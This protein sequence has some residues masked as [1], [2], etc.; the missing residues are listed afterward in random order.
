[1]DLVEGPSSLELYHGTAASRVESIRA[2]GLVPPEPPRYPGC[3]AMLTSSWD[4]AV[5]NS[6][7]QPLGDR[8]VI[9]YWV[10]ENQIDEHLF[11]P[12]AMGPN[13]WYTVRRPLPGDT[14][15]RVT[16]LGADGDSR[17]QAAAHL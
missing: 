2:T 4:D 17:T 9:T 6:R 15:C 12:M 3:W 7:R 1:M 11:P 13:T 14:I 8:A 16:V 10:P 5:G